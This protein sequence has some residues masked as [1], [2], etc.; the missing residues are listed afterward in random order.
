MSAVTTIV[1][2]A[3]NAKT[4]GIDSSK[5]ARPVTS[6]NVPANVDPR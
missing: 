6:A 4:F 1:T 2:A 5:S 3:V